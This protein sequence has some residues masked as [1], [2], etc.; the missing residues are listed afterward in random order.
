MRRAG[1]D[2]LMALARAASRS[3]DAEDLL[4]DALIAAIAAGRG[5]L[6]AR[7]DRAWLYGTIRNLARM[8]WR[9]QSRRRQR[10]R[11]WAESV[12]PAAA[13][14]PAPP[15]ELLHGLRPPLKAVAA[16]ALTGHSRREIAYLLGISDAA[17]RQRLVQL[18]R[19][20]SAAG[21]TMPGEPAG[22]GL[23][24]A[25]GR[26]R[27]ALLPLLRRQGGALGSHDPDGHIFVITR[28]QDGRARQSPVRAGQSAREA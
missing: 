16:L 2:E 22:L 19:S 5:D 21:V 8:Q 15:T 4:H 24:L 10:E 12:S 23:D 18:R 6:S 11:Q 13:A 25:Y 3:G 17:L 7:A 28:S 27:A 26:L 14:G 1:Y 9:G 20:L